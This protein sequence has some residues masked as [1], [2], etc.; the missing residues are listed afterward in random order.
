[1][2]AYKT[3]QDSI[4]VALIKFCTPLILSGILQQLY[5]WVD[6]F[7]V[8]NVV[9]E[10]ALAAVG[11]VWAINNFYIMAITGFTTGLSI[12]IAQK[13]GA[14]EVEDIRKIL[15][16]F[17][18]ILG[19]IVL[20]VSVFA[21][22]MAKP[23]LVIMDTPD[24]IFGY[25]QTYLKIIC[26]GIPFLTVY[27]LYSVTL[28]AMGDSRAPFLAVLVS[29]VANIIL[30]ILFVAVF[31]WGVAG[32]AYATMISQIAMT[33]FIVI[34]GVKKYPE[35]RFKI[36]RNMIHRDCI[37]KSVSFGMPTMLQ[38]CITAFG[39]MVLQGFMN[40]F[41]TATVAAITT[42]YRV[43]SIALLPVI[44]LGSGISTLVA[45]NHGAGDD[46]KSWKVFKTGTAIMLGTAVV[47]SL[48]VI[49][50]GGYV[51]GIFGVGAEA[52]AIGA[53]FFR[54]LGSFYTIFGISMACRGFVEGMGGVMH[55]SIFGVTALAVRIVLSYLLRGVFDNMVIAYAEGIS[56]VFM[57]TLY[58]ARCYL[59]RKKQIKEQV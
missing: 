59:V 55:S 20:A 4:A 41:G 30:D 24:D 23:L 25:S 22:V 54:C 5:N 58:I 34:Y 17:L 32:A 56:W 40:S 52:T 26:I 51:V 12:L 19:V 31:N 14:G 21:F 35:I 29:S 47:L 7:I 27:N 38:S 18:C 28:R 46:H 43:D 33:V 13:F 50:F 53:R 8:G 3:K 11:A 37:A 9:G 42:A 39:N 15:S 10:G 48:L 45:Q 44:N 2:S 1:M 49:A 16:T 6:A 36:G 57:M